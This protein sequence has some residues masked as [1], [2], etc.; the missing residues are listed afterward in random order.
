MPLPILAI[1]GG[2]MTGFAFATQ[3]PP[4][5]RTMQYGMNSLMPNLELDP[6]TLTILRMRGTISDDEYYNVM[7]KQGYDKAHADLYYAS[8]KMRVERDALLTLKWRGEIKEAEYYQHMQEIG[9]TK[10]QIDLYEKA[11]KYYPPAPDLVRFAVREVYT[12][13]IIKKYGLYEDLPPK[14]IDEAKKVGMSEEQ[15][16]N[17]WAAHWILPDIT[18]G[19][20]MLHRGVIDEDDLMTLM[21]VSDIMPYWRDKLKAI[22]YLPYTRVDVRRMYGLGVLNEEDVK[23]SY[24]DLGYDEEKAEKMTQFTIADALPEEKTLTKAQI[25]N[26]WEYGELKDGD[27]IKLLVSLGYTQDLA[28]YILSLWKHEKIDKEIKAKVELYKAQYSKGVINYDTLRDR[29][30]KL[31]LPATRLEY[32]LVK[33]VETKTEKVR[34]PHER[35]IMRFYKEKLIDEKTFREY[36]DLLGYRT[37]DIDLYIEYLK[38]GKPI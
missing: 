13:E 14:F 21:R 30:S 11:A 18:L 23:R 24:L 9:W 12:P 33:A 10:E 25:R 8:A 32:E 36:M 6:S 7:K 29:L 20:E 17:Y 3:V 1:L 31:N 15:A 37:E 35:D 26:G 34:L 19:Y 2:A 4:L 38:K 28:N 22:S 5:A 27:T 16:R